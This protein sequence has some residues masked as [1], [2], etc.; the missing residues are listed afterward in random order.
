MYVERA[1]LLSYADGLAEIEVRCG[2]GTYIRSIAHDLG[3]ALGCG[4]H[5]A[6][7]RRTSSGG[8]DVHG[9]HTPDELTSLAGEGRLDE[10]M[11]APDRAVERRPAAIFAEEHSIDVTSGRDVVLSDAREASISAVR[12]RWRAIF[13]ES[14][15]IAAADAG[16]R[17][18]WS[19][20]AKTADL[21]RIRLILARFAPDSAQI[22][23]TSGGSGLLFV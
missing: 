22:R 16:T 9:A 17:R 18:R 2:K 7:L 3:A 8:F 5:L 23:L 19:D 20:G 15:G 21:G 1:T 12:T 11:L 14:C 6:A 10:A 13:W 4:A